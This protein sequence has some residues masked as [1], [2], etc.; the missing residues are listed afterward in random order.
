MQDH[1]YVL[2]QCAVESLGDTIVLRCIVCGEF[3]FCSFGFQVLAKF[4]AQVLSTTIRP[5][6]LNDGPA[7]CFHPC[8]VS[9]IGIEGLGF[10]CKEIK[11]C[12]TSVVVRKRYVEFLVTR[13]LDV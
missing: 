6:T 2:N 4:V 10:C 7:L 5:K 1:V 13:G 9:F 11:V 12:V 3:L 8:R